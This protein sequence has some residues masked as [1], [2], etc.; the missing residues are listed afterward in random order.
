[1]TGLTMDG[2]MQAKFHL[3]DIKQ[4]YPTDGMD[5]RGD[6]DFDVQTKGRYIPKSKI[7][8]VTK[9]SINLKDGYV[10]TKYYPHPIQNLQ[11]STNITNTTGTLAG[12][13]V[14]IK[15]VSLTFEGEPFTLKADLKNFADL[16]Y[17][18][19]S[20]GT[21]DIG[22]IYKVF[23]L[24]GYGVSGLI[25]TNFTLKGKQSDATAGRYD[26][27]F[28]KGTMNVKDLSL[29]SDLF[30]KPFVIKTGK[31]SFN[32]DKMNFDAFTAN[33]GKSVIVM[34][35]A[36]SNVI[37]YAIKPNS[38]L[39]GTFNMASGLIVADDFMAFA[40]GPPGAPGKAAAPAKSTAPT[41]VVLIAANLNL[42][43]TADVK[44]VKYQG[45]DINDVKGQ[46]TIS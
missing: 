24:K 46:M 5:I 17:N 16:Q 36:L 35:G 20:K 23:A 45:L 15:P 8:P 37:D 22:K 30:P 43:F 41:G 19:S 32:Q 29:S 33:Y 26:Q 39:T 25:T 44:K 18:I 1:K 13:K 34:N 31:F 11:I 40:D 10:Q 14:N 9:A 38:P 28:N 21:L 27:L 6:L 7:F 4:I 3:A 2:G 12:M 42:T